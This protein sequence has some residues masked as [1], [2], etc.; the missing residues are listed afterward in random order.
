ML[1]H[2]QLK[3]IIFVRFVSRVTDDFEPLPTAYVRMHAY[4]Y[5]CV[6][7]GHRFMTS[8]SIAIIMCCVMCPRSALSFLTKS[9]SLSWWNVHTHTQSL[10]SHTPEATAVTVVYS[11]TIETNWGQ[12]TVNASDCLWRIWRLAECYWHDWCLREQTLDD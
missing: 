5:E 6:L 12:V 7:P 4:V 8:Y 9:H 1:K 2:S 3:W 10:V 11:H